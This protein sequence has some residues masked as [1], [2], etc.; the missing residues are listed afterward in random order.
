M[1]PV[2]VIFVVFVIGY[3]TSTEIMALSAIVAMAT[4]WLDPLSANVVAVIVTQLAVGLVAS[5]VK[6][7]SQ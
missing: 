5:F 1:E 2:A 6:E 7:A 3:L 4:G